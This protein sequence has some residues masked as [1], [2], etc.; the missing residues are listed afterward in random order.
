LHLTYVY[1]FFFF[2]FFIN[3][4]FFST[5]ISFIIF[6]SQY[7]FSFV[8]DNKHDINF[9]KRKINH[10]VRI[11][12]ETLSNYSFLFNRRTVH[13]KLKLLKFTCNKYRSLRVTY[14]PS[15][16]YRISFERPCSKSIIATYTIFSVKIY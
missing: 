14:R 11:D 9:R 13:F 12:Y 4:F 3:F 2:F 15:P 1:I 16:M 5:L 10:A 6:Y 7:L 8:T